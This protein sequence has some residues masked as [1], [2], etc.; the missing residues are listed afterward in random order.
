MYCLYRSLY[1]IYPTTLVYISVYAGVGCYVN[2]LSGGKEEESLATRRWWSGRKARSRYC[3]ALGEKK[4]ADRY[5]D[6]CGV[7]SFWVH[8]QG[9]APDHQRPLALLQCTVYISTTC[10]QRELYIRLRLARWFL[11]FTIHPFFF[12]FKAEYNTESSGGSSELSESAARF[13]CTLCVINS[14]HPTASKNKT[15]NRIKQ[16]GNNS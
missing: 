15:K 1:S 11:F 8:Q 16:K 6:V 2:P 12:Y 7:R 13:S 3:W 4:N 10:V 14:V 5:T 9:A